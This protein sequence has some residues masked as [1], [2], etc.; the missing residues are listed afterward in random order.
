MSTDAGSSD[1][2]SRNKGKGSTKRVNPDHLEQLRKPPAPVSGVSLVIYFREGSLVRVISGNESV[3]IGRGEAYDSHFIAISDPTLSWE[4]ARF[5]REGDHLDVEDLGSQN[6]TYVVGQK[7]AA[8]TRL[9]PGAEVQM[10]GVLVVVTSGLRNQPSLVP[11]SRF[12]AA[13]QQ[14]AERAMHYGRDFAVLMIRAAS[15]HNQEVKRFLPDVLSQLRPFHYVA[16]HSK[17]TVEVLLPEATFEEARMIA[18]SLVPQASK[19]GPRRE[20]V[21]LVVSGIVCGMA[22]GSSEMFEAANLLSETLTLLANNAGAGNPRIERR[23]VGGEGPG[24]SGPNKLL[25]QPG[26]LERLGK[27]D[28]MARSTISILIEGETGAGKSELVRYIHAHSPR[29]HGPL[30]VVNCAAI[31]DGLVEAELFGQT[32]GAFTDAK[33]KA[34]LFELADDGTLFL[35]EIGDLSL[36]AQA[37]I[38]EAVQSGEFRRVGATE[39]KKVNVRLIAATNKD[40]QTLVKQKRF[41]EDLYFRLKNIA[42]R[43]PPLRERRD[44]IEGLAKWFL[45]R[46]KAADKRNDIEGFSDEVLALFQRYP[47]PGNVRELENAV[48]RAVAL[49]DHIWLQPEDFPELLQKNSDDPPRWDPAIPRPEQEFRESGPW[50]GGGPEEGRSGPPT[51]KRVNSPRNKALADLERAQI[52]EAYAAENGN[53]T[54]AAAR[55]G[56]ATRTIYNKIETL[57]ITE[58]ELDACCPPARKKPGLKK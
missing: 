2:S 5:I 29:R 23:L 7:I 45:E 18:G 25:L 48:D 42:M 17:D 33:D 26:Y 31:P 57:G 24:I 35:D 3:V 8:R 41:R 15:P 30:V 4:H 56:M 38:L 37:K 46:R 34:G 49:S 1:G 40:L 19:R 43:I 11:H 50:E 53:K 16:V 6:G 20:C 51:P 9:F 10:G 44:E 39:T 36:S 32:K 52:L 14:E 21:P 27:L 47:W 54:K 28:Q 55:L 12:V 22:R 13:V 58:E